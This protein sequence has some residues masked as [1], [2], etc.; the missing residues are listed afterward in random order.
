MRMPKVMFFLTLLFILFSL[1]CATKRKLY[2]NTPKR[3]LIYSKGEI[4]FKEKIDSIINKIIKGKSVF[5][6]YLPFKILV[7]RKGG[8]DGFSYGYQ[9]YIYKKEKP[10]NLPFKKRMRIRENFKKL[11]LKEFKI[12]GSFVSD[13]KGW[14]PYIDGFETFYVFEFGGEIDNILQ[15]KRD[16]RPLDEAP[17]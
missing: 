16:G 13:V 3:D 12:D 9:S 1:S 5:Y 6:L 15:L 11:F 14:S 17:R 7:N 2:T 10:Y 8:V 4:A